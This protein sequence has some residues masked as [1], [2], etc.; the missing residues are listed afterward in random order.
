[1]KVYKI[2]WD[3]SHLIKN[4]YDLLVIDKFESIPNHA[5][6]KSILNEEIPKEINFK[7]NFSNIHNVNYPVN[8]L[9][10]PIINRKIFDVFFETVK[11]R[12]VV[13]IN[14]YH[15]G[16]QIDN[17]VF[18]TFQLNEYF[19]CF[20]YDNSVYESNFILPITNISKFFVKQSNFPDVFRN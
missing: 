4:Q 8:D 1:M 11:P 13:K 3:F 16:K 15:N 17:S 2:N 10:L 12:K 7:A 6:I 9:A 20:D 5:S 14:I 18:C 19:D